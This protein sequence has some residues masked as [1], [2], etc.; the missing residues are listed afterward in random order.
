MIKDYFLLSIRNLRRRK[1][2]SW[3][4]I[5]GVFIGIAAIVAFITLGQGLENY[6]N[7]QFEQMGKDVVMVMGKAGPM[8]SP[9]ASEMSEKP[10][11]QKDVDLINKISG[12]KVASP[13]IMRPTSIKFSKQTENLFLYGMEPKDI[14]D[15]FGD[16]ESFQIDEGR[17]LKQDDKYKAVVGSRFHEIFDKKIRLGSKLEIYEE[18][19]EIIG[20]MNPIGNPQD[21]MA[22]YVPN[23][24]LREILDKPDKVSMIYVMTEKGQAERVAEK[25]E[26]AMRKD[27]G[28]KEEIGR[29][30]V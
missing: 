20:I 9:M 25:I 4:T 15:L 7:E 27:R 24:I 16:L 12:V 5:I 18:K 29:A 21:D 3:L 22:I 6:I 8:V 10:L 2:R 26:K 23:E 11:T 1:L 30:H 19:F 14:D 17:Q 28:E 13:M